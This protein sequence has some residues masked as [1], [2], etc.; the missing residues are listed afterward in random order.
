VEERF[1]QVAAWKDVEARDAGTAEHPAGEVKI[2]KQ[3]SSA[4]VAILAGYMGAL[5]AVTVV[6]TIPTMSQ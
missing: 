4:R 2:P 5:G 6:P 1:D 3:L